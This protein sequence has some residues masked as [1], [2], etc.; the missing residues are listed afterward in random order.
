MG[1]MRS[2]SILNNENLCQPRRP[3]RDRRLRPVLALVPMVGVLVGYSNAVV[4]QQATQLPGIVVQGATLEAEPA[5][6]ATKPKPQPSAQAQTTAPAPRPQQ[7]QAAAQASAGNGG[8]SANALDGAAAVADVGGFDGLA[9]DG[10]GGAGGGVPGNRL[11]TS[12]SVVTSADLEARQIRHAADALRALPGVSVGRTGGF[13]GLTELRIRGAESDHTLVVID[14]IVANSVSSAGF[15]F[16]DL[17]AADIERIEVIRGPQSGLYGSGAIGGVVNIVTKAG[18]GP[19]RLTLTGEGGSFDTRAGGVTLSGGNDQAHGLIAYH[20]RDSNGFDVAPF[21]S[22]T[23]PA[24]LSTFIL[25]GGVQPVQNF[26]IDVNLR[27]VTKTGGRD[28]EGGPAGTLAIQTDVPSH[29]ATDQFLA[30]A[31]A[32]LDSFG[33]ALTQVLFASH[34]KTV[35]DDT[36]ISSFGTFFS[37]NISKSTHYGY[38]ATYRL[39]SSVM[40]SLKHVFTGQLH[41]EDDEFT[42]KGD[43]GSN[44]LNRRS[45]VVVAGEY[46]GE[47]ANRVFVTGTLRHDDNDKFDDFTTWRTSASLSLREW[48]LRPHASAG[49]GVK[50]PSMFEQFGTSALFTPNPNLLPERSFGWDAGVEV[51]LPVQGLVIDVTYFDQDLENQIIPLGFT[52]VTNDPGK[53]TRRG[54]EVA[55]RW[56]LGPAL[57][58]GGAYTYLD[59]KNSAGLREFRRP[60]HAGRADLAYSFDNKRGLITLS[61]IYNGAMDDRAFLLPFF[62]PQ[63]VRLDDYWLASATASYK[64][65]P[66]VEVFGRVENMFDQDYQEVFGFQTAGVNAY[67]GIKFKFA[68]S[69]VVE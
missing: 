1:V 27:Q 40:P 4:A 49:T 14:G 52:S 17:S 18:K 46:R 2:N 23:E 41:K 51:T 68:A 36:A 57:V 44:Q 66:R 62:T 19:L 3:K 56:Q 45:R 9:S 7:S 20:I 38:K 31:K 13:G 29:F 32:S 63:R 16:S 37:R 55:A 65:T 39:N 50:L 10:A 33:G 12:V 48:G 28:T 35:Q 59:A 30:G 11:G 67:A 22:E 47:F 60:Q 54:I 61:A 8:G 53:S 58:I 15:D 6:P 26:K 43:F 21:G 34:N 42:P 64:L 69:S 25:K 24:R 5:K